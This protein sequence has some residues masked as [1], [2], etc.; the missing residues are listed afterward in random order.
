MD[1]TVP[2]EM[3][4]LLGRIRSYIEE[5]VYPAELQ[6]TDRSD[7]LGSCDV[8]ERLRDKAR[9]RGIYTPHLPEEYG[10]LGIEVLGMDLISQECPLETLA[11]LVAE[12]LGAGEGLMHTVM[13]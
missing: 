5:E 11:A 4:E 6:I 13:I 10:G 9:E 8:V 1:F 7:I 12:V 3:A 2:P